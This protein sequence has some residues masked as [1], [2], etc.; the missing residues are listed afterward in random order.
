[1]S[2]RG[3]WVKKGKNHLNFVSN[4]ISFTGMAYVLMSESDDKFEVLYQNGTSKVCDSKNP[5]NSGRFLT[6]SLFDDKLVV[7]GMNSILAFKLS[8]RSLSEFN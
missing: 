5:L 7:C 3:D 2:T 8:L 4:N 1:M 6:S